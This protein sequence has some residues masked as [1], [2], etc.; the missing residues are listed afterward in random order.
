MKPMFLLP[1]AQRLCLL[2]VRFLLLLLLLGD[3]TFGLFGLDSVLQ[4]SHTRLFSVTVRPLA[5]TLALTNREV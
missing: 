3:G 2:V 4:V 1:A 5:S